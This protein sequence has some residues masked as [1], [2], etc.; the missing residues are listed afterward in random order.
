VDAFFEY[1]G[2]ERYLAS[3][4]TAGPWDAGSQHGGPPSA[5]LARAIERCEPQPAQRLARLSVD[6]L[7][8]VPV[9]ELSVSARVIRAGRRVTLVDAVA[10]S[11]GQPVV[12]AG[13]WRIERA[14]E[15]APPDIGPSYELPTIGEEMPPSDLGGLKAAGYLTAIE[16][17]AGRG[18]FRQ[19][20]PSDVWGRSRIPLV[21]G[22]E[23][24]PFCRAVVIADSGSGV[25]SVLD[26]SEWLFI[27]VDL[28]IDLAR[29]PVGEWILIGSRT[30][31]D[32]CG[33]GIAET[34][35]ADQSG[36]AGT[37][38]QTLLVSRR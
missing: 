32:R 1:L 4:S 35:I 27:N 26:A 21:A 5:L 28:T 30:T 34:V 37:G 29:D 36:V 15:P 24:S 25:S 12:R 16:W 33:T 13:G 22:E 8:P 2:G 17:R 10:S 38:L 31:I 23:T 20:G 3:P 11:D 9:G 18:S 14:Q 6:I 7:R 19:L